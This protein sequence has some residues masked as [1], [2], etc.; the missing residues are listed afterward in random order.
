MAEWLE[1]EYDELFA[2]HPATDERAPT[3]EEAA[4]LSLTSRRHTA[5]AIRAQWDDARSFLLGQRNASSEALRD[6]V[7]GKGWA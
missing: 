6:Y 1:P 5:A 4:A 3:L 7:V 2:A